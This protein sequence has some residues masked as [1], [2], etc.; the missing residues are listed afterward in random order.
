MRVARTFSL[1]RCYD[2][3]VTPSIAEREFQRPTREEMAANRWQSLPRK[4]G[5]ART[6]FARH[7]I[8]RRQAARTLLRFDLP[9]AMKRSAIPNSVDDGTQKLL[10]RRIGRATT[11]QVCLEPVDGQFL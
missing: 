5:A 3:V 9:R 2:R 11:F 7:D 10:L 6:P 1:V 4:K 8:I